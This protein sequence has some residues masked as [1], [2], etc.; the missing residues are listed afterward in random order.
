MDVSIIIV[1]YNTFNLTKN[2]IE[3]ILNYSK[4]FDYEIIV[5][6]NASVDDSVNLLKSIYDYNQIKIIASDV[7]LGFGKANN[8][9]A[10]IAKGEYIFF[11]NSDCILI[12]NSIK[13]LL[14]FYKEYSKIIKLG[15][16]GTLLVDNKLEITN[17]YG[18]FPTV[19]HE[20][21]FFFSI[22]LMKNKK[23]QSEINFED[24]YFNVDYV[25]GANMFLERKL[26]D[27]VDGFNDCFFIY[28]EETDLQYRLSNI[29]YKS[30]ILPIKGIIHLEDGS[31]DNVDNAPQW[32]RV[33]FKDSR[34]KY[35]KRNDKFYSLFYLFNLIFGLISFLN[36]RYSFKQNFQFYR[37]G[38]F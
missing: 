14:D 7:N 8:V 36:L 33:T 19:F 25:S 38:L 2:C 29:G 26:F 10:N 6:D 18:K 17:S 21:K 27:K 9:G 24:K 12:N 22:R 37:T 1:N 23:E 35:I 30:Y 5:I 11:L 15:V 31:T 34:F 32:K 16:L 28:F 13:Y 20:I 4:S 3:S